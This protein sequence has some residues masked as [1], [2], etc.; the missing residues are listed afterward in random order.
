M[1]F[2]DIA[3]AESYLHDKLQEFYNQTWVLRDR[4]RAIASLMDEASKRNNQQ[5]MGQLIVLKTQVQQFMMDQLALEQQLQPFADYFGI[6]YAPP[7]PASLGILPIAL[8]VGAV[9]VASLLYLHFEKLQNQAKALD[10]IAKGML[11]ADQANAIL[12]PPLFSM[13]GMGA[14]GLILA[15]VAGLVLWITLSR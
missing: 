14:S 1:T 4:L 3:S 5:V 9:A 12:N 7:A 8:A 13:A 11:P 2:P 6:S 15:G 10:L